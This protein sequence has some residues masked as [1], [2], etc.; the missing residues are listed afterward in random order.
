MC[1]SSLDDDRPSHV[2][3]WRAGKQRLIDAARHAGRGDRADLALRTI[4]IK[5]VD[6]ILARP[7]QERIAPIVADNE[8]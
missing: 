3:G 2:A 4:R 5:A 1:P 7:A 6:Q 8:G